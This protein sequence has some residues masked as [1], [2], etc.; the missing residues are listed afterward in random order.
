M[1]GAGSKARTIFQKLT[2]TD[3]IN[4]AVHQITFLTKYYQRKSKRALI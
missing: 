4:S 2:T 1:D 3:Y